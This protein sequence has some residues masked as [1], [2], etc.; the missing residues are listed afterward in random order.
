MKIS[1]KDIYNVNK[2]SLKDAIVKFWRILYRE[3][4]FRIRGLVLTNHHCGFASIQSHS[5]IDN[6]FT[7]RWFLGQNLGMELPNPDL[8]VTFIVRIDDV[9]KAILTNVTDNMRKEKQNDC[10]NMDCVKLRL[11]NLIRI[12]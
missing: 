1:A 4:L 5:T 6:N 8:F 7:E 3:K 11:L 10:K 12:F 9:T 2:G